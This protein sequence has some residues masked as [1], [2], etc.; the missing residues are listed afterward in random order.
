MGMFSVEMN[1]LLENSST[2]PNEIFERIDKQA[3]PIIEFIHM[4]AQYSGQLFKSK[5]E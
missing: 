1:F 4:S 5:L 3:S 2:H